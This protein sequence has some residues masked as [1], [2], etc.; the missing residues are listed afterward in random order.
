MKILFF[1]GRNPKNVSGLS[2]KIWKIEQKGR[3]VTAWWG[4]VDVVGRK[5]TPAAR[6]Q[7]KTWRFRTEALAKED[8]G[9]RLTQKL[10]RGYEKKPRLQSS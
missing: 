5:I 7:S 6:L 8:A 4:P 3:A 2:W 9:R 1:T 10:N